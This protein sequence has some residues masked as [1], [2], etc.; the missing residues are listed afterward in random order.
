MLSTMSPNALND[1]LVN[2]SFCL[3]FD[4]VG[5]GYPGSGVQFQKQGEKGL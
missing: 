5:P 1:G 3:A 2:K 4:L